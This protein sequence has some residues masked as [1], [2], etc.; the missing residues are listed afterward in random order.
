MIAVWTRYSFPALLGASM[1]AIVLALSSV[2]C[3]DRVAHAQPGC[4]ASRLAAP[5]ARCPPGP[6]DGCRPI[7]RPRRR[8]IA[9]TRIASAP[10]SPPIRVNG[11]S[12][13]A[14]PARLRTLRS[15]CPQQVSPQDVARL[16]DA[17]AC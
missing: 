2:L 7:P 13:R 16:F 8:S 17:M 3:T 11:A 12:Y 1:L 14:S 5:W 15:S 10:T 4:T 9:P 6:A